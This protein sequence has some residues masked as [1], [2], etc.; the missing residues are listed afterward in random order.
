MEFPF[1]KICQSENETTTLARIFSKL[2]RGGEVIAL[3][4]ELGSGKTFFVREVCLNFEIYDVT[5]P[6]FN[7]V[8]DYLGRKQI[9]HFDFYRIKNIKELYDI[10][11][12]E[13]LIDSEAIKFIEW[14]GLFPGILPKNLIEI[15]IKYLDEN[16]REIEITRK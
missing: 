8:N 4:G 14:A 11:F 3:N 13:Y 9:Y 12:E 15:N 10:G 16:R 5:S 1:L 6:S 2:L 7:I